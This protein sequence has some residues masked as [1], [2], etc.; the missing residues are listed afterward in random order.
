MLSNVRI[1]VVVPARDEAPRIQ[2]VLRSMPPCVDHLVVVDDASS[3]GTAP[4]ARAVCDE[5]VEVLS[6]ASNRG[7]GAAIVTGYKR[8]LDLVDAPR[9]AIVVMAGDGQMDPVDL[10]SV[11]GPVASGKADY[12]KGNRFAW[13]GVERTM[14][15][16]RR[17]GGAA[18]SWLTS[19]A[20]GRPI[21]DSQCGYTALARAACARLD[22]DALWPRYGY[23][24]DLL[25]QIASCGLTIAEVPVRPIYG[26]IP[27]KLRPY[28]VGAIAWIVAR[29]WVRRLVAR[30]LD[31]SALEAIAKRVANDGRSIPADV[32]AM[33]GNLPDEGGRDEAVLRARREKDRVDLRAEVGVGVGNLELVLEVGRSAQAAHDDPRAFAPAVLDEEA[34]ERFDAYVG[35]V[36]AHVLHELETLLDGEERGA[37]GVHA[38]ADDDMAE[39]RARALDEVEVA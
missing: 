15:F 25:G 24:N 13:P 10:P 33:A 32:S 30:G 31:R 8:A 20:I 34:V 18:F 6:H 36:G 12:V 16:A 7:V 23:P 11:V 19:L 3:D 2:R 9:D 17:T 14:P 39:E 29:A 37:R 27:S 1:V 4:L 28:H 22:L 26:G 38:D 35:Q 21:T 5:R